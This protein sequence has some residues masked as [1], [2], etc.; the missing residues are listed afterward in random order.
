VLGL[1]PEAATWRKDRWTP[2]M[3]TAVFAVER[4]DM[5]S[6]AIYGLFAGKKH[7]VPGPLEIARPGDEPKRKAVTDPREIAAWFRNHFKQ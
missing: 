5:W 2:E 1:P 3:E 6:R 4:S 7:G